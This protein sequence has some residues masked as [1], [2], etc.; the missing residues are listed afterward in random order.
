VR[1]RSGNYVVW[2]DDEGRVY[3]FMQAGRPASAVFRE[4]VGEE[5]RRL[6]E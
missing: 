3:K 4:G 1:L 6:G 2:A 5:T